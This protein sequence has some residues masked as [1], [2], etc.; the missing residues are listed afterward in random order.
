MLLIGDSLN[1]T[2]AARAAG[3]HVFC[4]PYGYNHGRHVRELDQ[5]VVVESILEATRL[6]R[7][8]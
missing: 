7:K 6:I 5:D 8:A 1:D 2:Q 4:V 3:C